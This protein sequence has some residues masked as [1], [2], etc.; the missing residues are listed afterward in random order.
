MSLQFEWD[1]RKAETNLKK[2]QVSF[3]E[4]ITV[5]DDA[6]ASIFDDEDHSN[7]ESREIIIGYSILQRLLLVCFIQREEDVVRII[8]ARQATRKERQ[9]HEENVTH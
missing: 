8:S 7:D 5:F 6:L 3:G 1:K 2:H 4:A 9:D